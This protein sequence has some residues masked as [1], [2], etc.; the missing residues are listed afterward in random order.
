MLSAH[1]QIFTLQHG[2]NQ[3][4]KH[5][6]QDVGIIK[7]YDLLGHLGNSFDMVGDVHG[8]RFREL[9]ELK[10]RYGSSFKCAFMTRNPITRLTSVKH[11]YPSDGF[12]RGLTIV[13]C[14][15]NGADAHMWEQINF[16][17]GTWLVGEDPIYKME[18]LTSEWAVV[19]SL[20]RYLSHDYSKCVKESH[21]LLET[22]GD[23]FNNQRSSKRPGAG[24]AAK[25]YSAE[26]DFKT[27][28]AD[29][30]KEFR[31]G[32]SPQARKAYEL[33]GY[34]LSFI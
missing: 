19:D 23:T 17:N 30:R 9:G 27:W 6:G 3:L 4:K 8:I 5:L 25:I 24:S 15:V 18:E 2:R 29:E 16:V 13:N 14:I 33:M 28:T 32:F 7:Y 20:L 22:V 34:D 1:P 11:M 31:Q 26:E 12:R 10:K 21:G